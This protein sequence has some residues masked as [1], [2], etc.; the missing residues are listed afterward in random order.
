MGLASAA[1]A[2]RLLGECGACPEPSAR[3]GPGARAGQPLAVAAP[4]GVKPCLAVAA[5]ISPAARQSLTRRAVHTIRC[6]QVSCGRQFS[7]LKISRGYHTR[8]LWKTVAVELRD[9]FESEACLG[10]SASPQL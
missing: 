2:E 9:K 5:Q 4:A 10:F 6:H 8:G 7:A 3:A 1:A